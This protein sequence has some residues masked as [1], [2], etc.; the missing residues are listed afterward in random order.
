MTNDI[1]T[2]ALLGAGAIAEPHARALRRLRNVRIVGV[3]DLDRQRADDFAKRFDTAAYSSF[4]ELLTKRPDVVHVL[5]PPA[6]HAQNALDA[7]AAGC[8]VY[9]EKPLAG[10]VEDCDRI[11]EAARAARRSVCVGHSQLYDPFVRR[12][13]ELVTRGAIGDVVGVDHLRSELYPPYAG[14][15]V[16]YRFQDGGFP[17]RDLGVHSL[18]LMAAFLGSIEDATLQLGEPS[19]DGCPVYKEWRT[20]V[21]CARGLGHIYL[22]WNQQP[23]QD[24]WIV[25]GTR[26]VIRADVMG[27]SVTV[28]KKRPLPGIATRI[29]NTFFEG[30]G[31]SAHV[32][33]SVLR[34]AC[35]RLRRYHGLQ[36]LVGE[37]YK[38]LATG[39]SPPVTVQQARPVIDW[40]E[41]LARQA[42]QAKRHYLASFPTTGTATV[43][44]TGGTGFIGRH[45]VRRLV[46]E[47]KHV[48]L[49]VR[50]PRRER[51]PMHQRTELFPGNL[52]NPADVDRAM[53]G[54]AEVYHLGATIDGWAEEFQC[55][56]IAGTQNMIDSA[57]AHRVKKFV[58]VS[59]LSVIDMAR[60]RGHVGI[61]EDWPFE[62]HPE[63]RGWYTQTKLAA[64]RMVADAVRERGLPAVMLRPGEVFGPDKVFLSGAVG[65]DVAGRVLVLGNGRSAG[66]LIW[67]GDLVDALVAA[68][69]KGPFDGTAYNLVDPETVTQ[70][71]LAEYY[72]RAKGRKPRIWH[73]PL[74]LLYP[75]S[76]V[77]QV[78]LR[79]LGKNSP[80][81][82]YRL[83]S[84]VGTR[85]FDCSAAREALGWEPRVGIRHGLENGHQSGDRSEQSDIRC[86][87]SGVEDKS[88]VRSQMVEVG[89]QKSAVS[90]QELMVQ[91]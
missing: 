88:D 55:A 52:G 73:L 49:L 30:C 85:R 4:D 19:R 27:M 1:T 64:E 28:R 39:Q 13:M 18:Y 3:A 58:Y 15:A 56:T 17:F 33:G 78:G 84:A 23:L 80:I 70:D 67:I 32:T 63:R 74:L 14:G 20:I 90:G 68:A 10:S 34:V 59:S 53:A 5:T 25:H 22:S 9:V 91:S 71:E 75:A 36:D 76:A 35:K 2:A 31:M 44:V 86:Q 43:L 41:R 12:A 60:A 82:P 61:C 47:G 38:S 62:P 79:L 26:G 83:K 37:F 8:H 77:L 46:A 54:I 72:L 66:P 89:S 16:P 6:A 11:A 7:L 48:R 51:A 87:M 50:G 81:T 29:L 21:R 24:V 45:L 42:D 57:I 69:E 65:R 40:T